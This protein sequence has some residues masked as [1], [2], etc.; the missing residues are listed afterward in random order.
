ML[1]RAGA[2]H[3][4]VVDVEDFIVDEVIQD[5][6]LDEEG[7]PTTP[8]CAAASRD[9]EIILGVSMTSQKDF[10]LHYYNKNYS[11]EQKVKAF[12]RASIISVLDSIS[13]IES[14]ERGKSV[15]MGGVA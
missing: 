13:C 2:K 15:V 8:I 1:V 11:S 3:L 5:F 7:R 12:S 6:W 10:S 14:S 9:A 4:Y